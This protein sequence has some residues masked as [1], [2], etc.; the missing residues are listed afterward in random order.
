M[1]TPSCSFRCFK[2]ISGRSH[3][4]LKRLYLHGNAINLALA[5]LVLLLLIAVGGYLVRITIFPHALR[6]YGL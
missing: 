1:E 6:T 3:Q 5:H 2:S 4:R